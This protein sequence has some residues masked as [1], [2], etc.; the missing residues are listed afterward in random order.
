M[1]NRLPAV[2]DTYAWPII[3]IDEFDDCRVVVSDLDGTLR[4]DVAPM[5]RMAGL[6]VPKFVQKLTL[7]EPLRTGKLI[8]FLVGLGRLW[9]LRTI[10][11]EHRRRY[12]YLFSE[13]H[14]L[15]AAL[16]TGMETRQ[17]RAMYQRT[18]PSMPTLWYPEA[19]DLLKR[20]TMNGRVVLVTGS[21]QIQTEECVR[22]LENH[23]VDTSRI[24]V[25]GSLYRVDPLTRRFTGGVT[26]LNVT[27]EGKRE[28]L[29]DYTS[30]VPTPFEA[31]LGNSRP[32]RALFE[33]VPADGLRV[34]VCRPSVLQKRK[35]SC[36][37]V[38]K[39]NRSGFPVLWNGKDYL[40]SINSD[41]AD[42]SALAD[43]LALADESE[44][45]SVTVSV[46][47]PVLATD[48]HFAELTAETVIGRHYGALGDSCRDVTPG[49]LT[50]VSTSRSQIVMP[51]C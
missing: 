13:L 45:G 40:D 10:N 28:S 49:E 9:C 5:I 22:L 39:L 17:L 12:K 2:E 38:R 1:N 21:E 50:G 15:A 32:D 30:L 27:L 25:H 33:A 36:F 8:R 51:S 48:R 44:R 29:L 31:A 37:V 41:V 14:T 46:C 3:P 23:G 6:L 35:Q 34:L 11:R 24:H 47:G 4:S 20:L 26:H 43:E 18:L 19:V 16:L 42:E 7:R